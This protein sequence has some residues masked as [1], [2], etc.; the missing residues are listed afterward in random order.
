[1]SKTIFY[2]DYRIMSMELVDEGHT[3]F[4]NLALMCLK[5]MSQDEVEDMLR[6]NQYDE[7]M[8]E[9]GL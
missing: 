9:Y 2:K 4:E 7:I 5:Y 8:Q 1:M 6:F 3:T